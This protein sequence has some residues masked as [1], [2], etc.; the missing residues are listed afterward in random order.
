MHCSSS[1]QVQQYIEV[2]ADHYHLDDDCDLLVDADLSK[3]VRE[4]F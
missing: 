3:L 4:S 2:T 1:S